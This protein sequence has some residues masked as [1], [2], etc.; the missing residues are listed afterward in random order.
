MNNNEIIKEEIV[1]ARNVNTFLTMIILFIAGLGFFLAGL[2]S[3]L[4]LNLLI[5]TDTSGIKFVPQ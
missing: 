2:S 4:G 3:Y 1:G 5:L